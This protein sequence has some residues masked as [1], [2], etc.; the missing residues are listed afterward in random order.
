M[1][2]VLVPPGRVWWL[3]AA[4][5]VWCV[6][7]VILYALHA[8]GCAFGWSAGALRWSLVLVF[9][10]HLLVIGWMWHKFARGRPDPATGTTGRFLHEAILW[11]VITAFASA[12]LALGPSLLLTTCI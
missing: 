11:T 4:F 8:I 6:A 9:I 3:A 1:N 10:A 2:A 12:V 7:L 5:V